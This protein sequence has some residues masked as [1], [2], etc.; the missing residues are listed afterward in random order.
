[1][2]TEAGEEQAWRANGTSET[3]LKIN[4]DPGTA[5]A[6]N[7]T[8]GIIPFLSEWWIFHIKNDS[9]TFLGHSIVASFTC[10]T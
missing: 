4:P 5:N 9:L 1:M 2:E 8:L 7:S 6:T 3:C 10:K